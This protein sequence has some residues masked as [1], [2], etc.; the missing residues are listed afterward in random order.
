MLEPL[1][2]LDSAQAPTMLRMGLKPVLDS[3]WLAPFTREQYQRFM[4]HKRICLEE[5]EHSVLADDAALSALLELQSAL[6]TYM[7]THHSLEL[8]ENSIDLRGIQAG[9]AVDLLTNMSSWIPDDI[10]ILQSA[11][12]LGREPQ[13]DYILTA[14]SV[15]SP[16]HWR[17]K[18]KFLKPLSEIHAQIPGFSSALTPKVTRFFN[19]LKAGT[20]VI[21]YNWGVQP[22]NA[23]NWQSKTEASDLS[24]SGVFYRSERQTLFR[25]RESGAVVFFIRIDLCPINE[26][27]DY[28]DDVNARRLLAE[29]I[30]ALPNE[31]RIYKGLNRFSFW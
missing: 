29:H 17:P 19:H 23:L 31:D 13:E 18:E 6:S 3:Q 4:K 22:G 7:Q 30:A 16:S 27:N 1:A 8:D 14:A 20:P 28:Y 5:P 12:S 24:E 21:R 26:L 9:S 10:C 25:L 2:H 11:K 15:L